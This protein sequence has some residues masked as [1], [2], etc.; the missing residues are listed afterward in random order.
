MMTTMKQG[1]Y[2]VARYDMGHGVPLSSVTK[3]LQ[4]PQGNPQRGY[5]MSLC[6]VYSPSQILCRAGLE[7]RWLQG[8]CSFDFIFNPFVPKRVIDEPSSFYTYIRQ[9]IA[10]YRQTY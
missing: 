2:R 7:P 1:P 10:W 9:E 6:A 3:V 5:G 4:E 8:S